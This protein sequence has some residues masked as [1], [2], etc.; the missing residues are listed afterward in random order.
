MARHGL[1]DLAGLNSV[2]ACSDLYVQ[3]NNGLIGLDG[4]GLTQVAGGV[5]FQNNSCLD[6]IVIDAFTDNLQVGGTI[7]STNNGENC[8]QAR[9]ARF[10]QS[11]AGLA[12]TPQVP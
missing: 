7:V 12:N 2:T 1:I 9:L 5:N 11:G 10:R 3:N 4:L 6:Q 8:N